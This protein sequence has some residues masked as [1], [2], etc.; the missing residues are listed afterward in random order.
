MGILV[1]IEK[2]NKISDKIRSQKDE[3]E[4]ILIKSSEIKN[5]LKQQST[6]IIR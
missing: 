2:I 5:M 1:R 4:T 3:L 6:K